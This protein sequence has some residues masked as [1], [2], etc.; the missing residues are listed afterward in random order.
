MAHGQRTALEDGKP[1]SIL[2][3]PDDIAE[4]HKHA[5]ICPLCGMRMYASKG[6]EKAPYFYHRDA[7]ACD[8]WA[9]PA[10]SWSAWWSGMLGGSA[11]A[12]DSDGNPHAAGAIIAHPAR[13]LNC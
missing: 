11:M 1:V 4:R 9:E 7:S 10:G 5:Y 12:S 3:V 8:I 13:V 2:D 6:R